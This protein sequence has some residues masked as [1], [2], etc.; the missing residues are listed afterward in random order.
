[1]LATKEAILGACEALAK[2]VPLDVPELGG[3]V[4]LRYMS[5]AE[6]AWLSK[7]DGNR[8]GAIAAIVLAD[9]NGARLFADSDAETLA[10]KVPNK[11]LERIVRLALEMNVLTKDGDGQVEAE[12]DGDAE[13]P[14]A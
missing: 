14:T 1:M 2:P 12:L 3:T 8:S 11:P 9:E 13:N 10:S 7:C 5:A 4:Y 6:A